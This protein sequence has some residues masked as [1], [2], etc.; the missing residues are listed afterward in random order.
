MTA[1]ALRTL[2]ET[3]CVERV[4]TNVTCVEGLVG[5]PS[6]LLEDTAFGLCVHLHRVPFVQCSCFGFNTERSNAFSACERP[7][8]VH[9]VKHSA[10]Y[11]RV[12][13]EMRALAA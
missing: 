11:V 10:T 2:V 9:P 3:R 13:E 5:T 12:A 8:S 4:A 1:S 7:I 6:T